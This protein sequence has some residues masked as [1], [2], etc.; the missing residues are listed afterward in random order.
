MKRM[1]LRKLCKIQGFTKCVEYLSDIIEYASKDIGYATAEVADSKTVE[2]YLTMDN[3]YN[4]E[5]I[6]A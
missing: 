6:F 3:V 4:D 1:V 2:N 5:K